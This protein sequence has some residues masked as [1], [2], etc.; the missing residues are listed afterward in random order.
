MELEIDAGEETRAAREGTRARTFVANR[1][2]R[3]IGRQAESFVEQA[4]EISIIF[5]GS[6]TALFRGQV[7]ARAIL[8]E[9]YSMGAQ[10]LPIVLVT[11]VLSGVVTSQQG[12]YQFT[13]SVPL[14]VVG[15]VVVSSIVLELGP[16]LTG[17]VFIGRVGARITAE[18]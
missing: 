12:G 9:M 8:R 6:L 4:G 3:S 16:V 10:S 13:G 5:W 14:Y 15:S 17:V 11:G 2:L 7:S 1:W 18:L